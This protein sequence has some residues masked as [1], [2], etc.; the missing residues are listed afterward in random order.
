MT[1]TDT[2]DNMPVERKTTDHQRKAVDHV[3]DVW[4]K[5]SGDQQTAAT[6]IAR[7]YKDNPSLYGNPY[8]AL[9][10]AAEQYPHWVLGGDLTGEA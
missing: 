4:A 1:I 8:R 10:W 7:A 9:Q 3:R 5:M 2:G 6:L